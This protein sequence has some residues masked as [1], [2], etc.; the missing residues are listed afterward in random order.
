MS[1]SCMPFQS[2]DYR[3]RPNRPGILTAL[4]L[5]VLS[6]S[7]AGAP[8]A[9]LWPYWQA[10][11]ETSTRA[12]NH[13]TWGE[14]LD[15][16]LVE[17]DDGINRVRYAAVTDA[18]R[19]ALDG[20]IERL[21][22]IQV[23]SLNRDEQFAFWVNLYNALTVDVVLDHYPVDS[24]RDIDISPGW[25]SDGPWGKELVTIE[26]RE[27]SLDDIEHRI[28]RPVWQDP[29]V[30]YV[31]NCAALGCPNLKP[32]PYAADGL[33]KQLDRQARTYINHPRGARFEDGDLVVSS[34]YDWYQEDFGGTE[35]GVISHLKE[36]AAPELRAGLEEAGDIDD[37]E[38]D[39]AL[40]DAGA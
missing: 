6:Q 9:D 38:Y 18:D 5:L 27:L 30:H 29:R 28:L 33:E 3:A 11:D 35:Q 14:F 15:E 26:D 1:T 34:I 2:G 13:G 10:H 23:T 20:Y 36:C 16:Y 4:F 19:K 22:N 39:W 8:G 25:F 12:L 7:A 24:I 37:Y 32:E 21:S 17:G 40:N 31:V